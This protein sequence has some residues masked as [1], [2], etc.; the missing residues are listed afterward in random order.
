MIGRVVVVPT[1]MLSVPVTGATGLPA[2][3]VVNVSTDVVMGYVPLGPVT[4]T[5][6]MQGVL[7]L[8]EPPLNVS[9]VSS[10]AGSTSGSRTRRR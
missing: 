3:G 6:T 10:A 4:L 1:P 2:A 7:A 9:A 5:P 8:V